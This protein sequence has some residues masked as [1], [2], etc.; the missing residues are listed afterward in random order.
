[1]LAVVAGPATGQRFR[2]AGAGFVL[3]RSR[4]AILF[5]ED[6]F[7]SAHHA[8]FAVREGRL[9]VRDENSA[10]GVYVTIHGQEL[11]QPLTQFVV[12]NRCLRYTG[13]IQPTQPVPGR[14]I[15]Y[16]APVPTA[17][18]LFGV[19]EILVGG[20][21]GR[22]VVTAAPLLT[23]GSGKCDLTFANEAGLALR[24]CEL[25][26]QLP[27]AV[28]RDLSGGLGT[29]VRLPPAVDRALTPGDKLRV[30]EQIIEVEA[31]P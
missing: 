25:S 24:H 13:G 1:M 7:I 26:P 27:G 23:I 3:G 14:P 20:R 10:S 17:Q 22:A 5:P 16:G 9:Y 12:A 18:A 2:L 31:V 30:G 29:F 28:L 6:P 11:V 19:E 21:P 8:T 15:I 4:G